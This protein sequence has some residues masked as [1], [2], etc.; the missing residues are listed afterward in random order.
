MRTRTRSAISVAALAAASTLVF[1]VAGAGATQGQPV[2]AGQGNTATSQ[3]LIA[4][5]SHV[6]LNDCQNVDSFHDSGLVVCSAV[7]LIALGNAGSGVRGAGRL[8][9][10]AGEG[11]ETGVSGTGTSLGVYAL[12]TDYGANDIGVYGLTRGSGKGIYGEGGP[13]GTGV[14][15]TNTGS[16]GIGVHGQTGGT[17]AAVFGEATGDGVGVYATSKTVPAVKGVGGPTGVYGS[18]TSDGVEGVSPTG[19]GVLGR[20]TGSTGVGVHGLTGG[21]GSA[22]YGQA[23]ANGVGVFGVSQSGTAL[24]GDSPNGTALQVNGKAKFSRSGTVTIASG[25]AS[26]TVTL[27]GVTAA[28]M[29]VATAQQNGSVFVKAAVPAGG[30]FTIFLNGNAPGS[31][32]KVAYFVLN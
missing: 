21:T 7:G 5:T 17:G 2:L 11:G 8:I 16:T 18:G 22:V 31:G 6:S 12:A 28:S 10:V 29:V 13:G 3:T 32:L 24:R 30:S 23:T 15:G 20:N 26:K 27:P 25:T 19:D 9:G 14:F 1:G 4:N